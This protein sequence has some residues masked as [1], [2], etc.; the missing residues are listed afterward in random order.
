MIR[1]LTILMLLISDAT[2]ASQ[3]EIGTINFRN[4]RDAGVVID[5]YSQQAS[6]IRIYCMNGTCPEKIMKVLSGKRSLTWSAPSKGDTLV[7]VL[8]QTDDRG[9]VTFATMRSFTAEPERA[10]EI[11]SPKLISFPAKTKANLIGRD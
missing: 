6:Q 11:L 1:I 5:L 8:E 7:V 10:R 3:H 4:T 2:F 9:R